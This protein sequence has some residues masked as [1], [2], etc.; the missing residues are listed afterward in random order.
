MEIYIKGKN[1]FQSSENKNGL[2]WY[3]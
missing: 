3:L 1:T 2:V